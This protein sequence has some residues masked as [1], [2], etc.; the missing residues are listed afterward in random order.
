MA[1]KRESISVRVLRPRKEYK[2]TIRSQRIVPDLILFRL[3]WLRAT[4]T[5]IRRSATSLD[6]KVTG[7]NLT[8]Q[9]V[10]ECIRDVVAT[11]RYVPEDWHDVDSTERLYGNPAWTAVSKAATRHTT[12]SR[13]L[14]EYLLETWKR[15]GQEADAEFYSEVFL[16]G[17]FDDERK[18]FEYMGRRKRSG[19]RRAELVAG[20]GQTLADW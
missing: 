9:N 15:E 6:L 5:V 19:D 3:F 1:G 4:V 8:L 7:H 11:W 2:V 18:F 17:A 20:I 13:R 12:S 14:L 10:E 16:R